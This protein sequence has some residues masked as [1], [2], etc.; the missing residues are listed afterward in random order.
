MIS[1][2]NIRNAI[3]TSVMGFDVENLNNDEDFVVAGL[4]SPDHLSILLNLEENYGV[5]KIPDEDVDLCRSIAGILDY[6]SR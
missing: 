6:L 1:E 2:K 3:Q 4:D 5:N